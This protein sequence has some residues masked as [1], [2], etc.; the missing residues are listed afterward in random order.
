[1]FPTDGEQ[2]YMLLR[3][4]MQDVEPGWFTKLVR[5]AVDERAP[6]SKLPKPLQEA[7]AEIAKKLF[8]RPVPMRLHCPECGELHVD[9]GEF[10]FKVHHTHS[11]QLCG[12]TW[13]PC[14]RPTVGVQFLPGFRNPT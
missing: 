13:R 14:V 12:A 3:D 6:F 7:M 8:D 11:C 2:L 4:F 1:M 9:V 5:L 10:E